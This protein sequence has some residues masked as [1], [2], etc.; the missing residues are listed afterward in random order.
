[1]ITIANEKNLIPFTSE[2]NREEAS[3]NGRKGG[4]ASGEAR[5]RKKLF[6]EQINLLLSLPLQDPKAKKQLE[7][8]GIDT[9]NIDNQMAMVISM[10]QKAIKGDV[11]AFNTLRDTAGEKPKEEIEV[12]RSTDETIKEI[13]D[14][15]CKKKN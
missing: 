2:Q 7:A 15:L 4:K 13:D 10:W 11:Q 9:D 8:L 14:Y 5:R 1:M 12:S 6:K 3:K